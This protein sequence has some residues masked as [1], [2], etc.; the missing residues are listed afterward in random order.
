MKNIKIAI[1]ILSAVL[2]FSACSAG[3]S[4]A[5]K[6]TVFEG[7]GYVFE[8]ESGRTVSLLTAPEAV[9]AAD[10]SL[11]HLWQLSGGAGEVI[12]SSED[13]GECD[14]LML[15]PDDG[16]LLTLA[17]ENG[18]CAGV[19][20][21][22]DLDGYLAAL[23]IFTD[24]T[25][26]A[27]LYTYYGSDMAASIAELTE[28]CAEK[29]P[30]KVCLLDENGKEAETSFITDILNEL[31][32]Y[33]PESEADVVFVLSGGTALQGE[34]YVLLNEELFSAFP[35]ERLGEAYGYIASQ[36]YELN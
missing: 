9:L 7:G 2:L 32:V 10:E 19:F 20:S 36:L 23:K 1:G 34:K 33:A 15:S 29:E 3:Q 13:L 30:K 8:D 28:L 11:L 24:I 17:E 27:S 16:E 31:A 35:M 21:P 26:R 22:G 18:V 4:E 14:F 12:T 5:A 6:N 25:G